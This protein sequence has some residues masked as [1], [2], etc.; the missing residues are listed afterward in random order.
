MQ[1]TTDLIM[2][3]VPCVGWPRERVEVTLEQLDCSSWLALVESAIR[4]RWRAVSLPDLR[5]TLCRHAAQ[6]H[7]EAVLAPW[8]VEVTHARVTAQ[9]LRYPR[10]IPEVVAIW[11]RLAAWS[12]DRE[13]ILEIRR[14][15]RE[16]NANAAYAYADAAADAGASSS[17]AYADAGAD[18]AAAYAD[19]AADAAADATAAFISRSEP[20]RSLARRLDAAGGAS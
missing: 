3:T 5:L 1:I 14:D 17:A 13:E 20:L 16:A 11:D 18:A 6:R 10:A 4:E 7:R 12:G 2:S 8:A 9:R 19:A 15:A